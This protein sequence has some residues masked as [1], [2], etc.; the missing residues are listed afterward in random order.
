MWKGGGGELT[1]SLLLLG[2]LHAVGREHDL[3]VTVGLLLLCLLL[4]LLA[5]DA[6]LGIVLRDERFHGLVGPQAGVV[7]GEVHQVGH[8]VEGLGNLRSP[9][10]LAVEPIW[11]LG[12]QV[13][14]IHVHHA[15]VQVHVQAGRGQLDLI[16]RRKDWHR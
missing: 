13:H 7:L 6:A 9:V 5:D 4:L 15:H 11:V 10:S 1:G 16:R 3:R 14:S 2:T 8:N 12:T